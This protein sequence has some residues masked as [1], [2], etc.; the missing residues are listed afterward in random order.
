[1]HPSRFFNLQMEHC[2]LECG[3]IP[4]LN[5]NSKV[6]GTRHKTLYAVPC[7]HSWKLLLC[8][9]EGPCWFGDCLNGRRYSWMTVNIKTSLE[10]KGFQL[11]GQSHWSATVGKF[12]HKDGAERA[13][14][15][16]QSQWPSCWWAVESP[17]GSWDKS[18]DFIRCYA[19][20]FCPENATALCRHTS[21]FK[22]DSLV[23]RD[24]IGLLCWLHASGLALGQHISA[25]VDF[26]LHRSENWNFF[27]NSI[28]QRIVRRHSF[29]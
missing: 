1:M 20:M 19:N 5:S 21:L 2:Q 24:Q 4:S 13:L 18:N 12:V 7:Y 22:L 10:E 28:W 23:H 8:L 27:L 16:L 25:V 3:I 17:E 29:Q 11:L 14:W 15:W 26:N 6:N 9:K